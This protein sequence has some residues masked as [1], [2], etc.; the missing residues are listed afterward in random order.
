MTLMRSSNAPNS[1]VWKQFI[2]AVTKI[3]ILLATILAFNGAGVPD[4]LFQPDTSC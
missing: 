3:P 2:L 1:A 4:S